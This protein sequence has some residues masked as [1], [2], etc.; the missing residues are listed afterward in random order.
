MKPFHRRQTDHGF[1]CAAG[2][3]H[4]AAS[5]I[6]SLAGKCGNGFLLVRSEPERPRSC[7]L[8]PELELEG[9]SLVIPGFIQHGIT[10]PGELLF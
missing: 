3:H 9:A 1:A 2:E 8:L 10:Q 4:N 7:Q 6:V 5:A